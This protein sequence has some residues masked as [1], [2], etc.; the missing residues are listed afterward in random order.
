LLEQILMQLQTKCNE[1]QCGNRTFSPGVPQLDAIDQSG[2]DPPVHTPIEVYFSPNGGR[3]RAIANAVDQSKTEV[4][5]QVYSFTSALTA[6]ALL[7]AH[8][9]GVKVVAVLDNPREP[10]NTHRPHSL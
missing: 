2:I 4:L 7:N 6:K 3:T 9:R 1:E 10:K 8:K 5:I